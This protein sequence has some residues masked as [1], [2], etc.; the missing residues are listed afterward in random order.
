MKYSIHFI[1]VMFF[2]CT[3]AVYAQFTG[4]TYTTAESAVARLDLRDGFGGRVVRGNMDLSMMEGAVSLDGTKLPASWNSMDS[5]DGWHEL[6]QNGQTSEICVLNREDVVLEEGRLKQDTTWTGS[7]IHLIRNNIYVPNGVTLTIT[8]GVVVKFTEDTRIIV[9]NGGKISVQGTEDSP[10]QFTLATDDTYGGDTDLR[11]GTMDVPSYSLID[12]YNTSNGWEDNGQFVVRQLMVNA[13]PTVSIH[14]SRVMEHEGVVMIP[15]TVSGTRKSA[16]YVDWIAL[17]GTAKLENDYTLSSG[18]LS[19]STTDDGTQYIQIPIVSDAIVEDLEDFTVTLT[20]SSGTNIDTADSTVSICESEFVVSVDATYSWASFETNEP[21]EVDER[22]EVFSRLARKTENLRYSTTWCVSNAAKRVR[23]TVLLDAENEGAHEIFTSADYAEGMVEWK[24]SDLEMGRYII[25]H[26]TLDEHGGLLERLETRFYINHDIIVH[27]GC[28]TDDETWDDSAIHVVRSKVIVPD[29]VMLTI[30][31][32]AIVKFQSGSGIEAKPGGLV[33]CNGATFTHIADDSVGGDTN[34]DGNATMPVHNAYTLTG[35][36]PGADCKMCYIMQTLTGGTINGTMTLMGNCV[37]QVTGDITIESG[38]KLIVQPG[39]VVKME[40]GKSITVNSGGTLEAIGN[41]AQPIVFTSI[42]DD[43]HGGDTNGDG[44]KTMPQSGDWGRIN[45]GGTVNMNYVTIAYLNNTGDKGAIQGTG[46]TVTFDNGVIEYSVYECVR[47]NSGSFMARNSVFR[48]ASMGFGYY[49]GSGT[50]CINCVITDVT[51]GCR[52]SNKYFTNCVFY[53]VNSITDQGGDNSSFK[54]CVFYNPSGYGVQSYKKSGTNGNI[55]A[56]PLFNDP[57]NGDFTLKEGSPCIDAGDGSVAPELDYF[58]QPRQD[59]RD[60]TDTGVVAENGAVP[61]IGI[62]EMLPRNAAATVDL[63]A[64]SLKSAASVRAGERLAVEWTIRNDGT[65]AAVGSWRDYVYLVDASGEET[66]LGSLATTGSIA[67]NGLRVN[68]ADFIVPDVNEGEYYLK[69]KCNMNRDIF[70][71]TLTVNNIVISE[72]TVAITYPKVAVKDG[73]SGSLAAG[74]SIVKLL[75]VEEGYSLAL[76]QA[77][78]GTKVYYSLGSIPTV[79]SHISS[80]TCL[81]GMTMLSLPEGEVYLLLVA[82]DG[83]TCDYQIDFTE[84][85]LMIQSVSQTRLPSTGKSFVRV[86]GS[87]FGSDSEVYLIKGA[88]R[89]GVPAYILGDN[90][91]WITIE[92][93]KLSSGYYDLQVVSAL[94]SAIKEN[95]FVATNEEGSMNLSYQVIQPDSARVG[96]VF[97]ATLEYENTGNVAMPAPV[98][99][100]TATNRNF[101]I[102]GT[103]YQNKVMLYGLGTVYPYSYLQPGVHQKLTFQMQLLSGAGPMKIKAF[104]AGT[105]ASAQPIGLVDIFSQEYAE[106]LADND[107]EQFEA[108]QN[109]LG[110]TWND[111]YIGLADFLC[112]KNAGNNDGLVSYDLLKCGYL[113]YVERQSTATQRI[114][115]YGSE[116]N[117]QGV[118]SFTQSSMRGRGRC[119]LPIETQ[120]D[121]TPLWYNSSMDIIKPDFFPEVKDSQE[122]VKSKYSAVPIKYLESQKYPG[123]FAGDKSYPGQIWWFHTSCGWWHRLGNHDELFDK[124][125]EQITAKNNADNWYLICHGNKNSIYDKWILDAA[126]EI[127]NKYPNS[128]V[129]AVDWGDIARRNF[130]GMGPEDAAPFVPVVATEA[131]RQLAIICNDCGL[132]TNTLTVIG[133][134]HGAHL[135]GEIAKELLKKKLGKV[136]RFVGLDASPMWTHSK[137]GNYYYPDAWNSSIAEQVEFYKTSWRFSMGEDDDNEV[138]GMPSFY[139]I[140]S[141]DDFQRDLYDELFKEHKKPFKWYHGAGDSLTRHSF[142]H[143]WFIDTIKTI[144]TN[145]H[146]KIGFEWDGNMTSWQNMAFLDKAVAMPSKK[147]AGVI[148]GKQLELGNACVWSANFDMDGKKWKKIET[149]DW[150]YDSVVVNGVGDSALKRLW[151]ASCLAIEYHAKDIKI[152]N[153]NLIRAGESVKVEEVISKV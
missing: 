143:D 23:L 148:H 74:E 38:G 101:I 14:N 48:E 62:H 126:K 145:D 63:V 6:S 54:N 87:C 7:A 114:V 129:F 21:V 130:E 47:M 92:N 97:S 122:F 26:E 85:R 102:D 106:S 153:D 8:E 43:A 22:T 81:D 93:E 90:D 134:S 12:C 123:D 133:H 4:L 118:A 89:I 15:V 104:Y 77:P 128:N 137:K 111:F 35:F 52:A 146:N 61:D 83:E 113:R 100:I 76:I 32:G 82:P 29:G 152:N 40:S 30:S 70:E 13:L 41:R 58:G 2:F 31:H 80:V 147:F 151:Y 25:A 119:A 42:K 27:E 16:F 107:A 5:E 109:A 120:L 28:L 124:V 20:A 73:I 135:G 24:T 117:L 67:P 99:V 95:A 19:W 131:S 75:D 9:E 57:D 36:T 55:W 88:E 94:G 59:I 37:Y 18:R 33:E 98:F 3:V 45:A 60:V 78:K 53:R 10:V 136:K 1:F 108:L 150:K 39:T 132:N 127:S 49:G 68:K 51:V 144:S 149:R 72:E 91:I 112:G 50:Q 141:K 105:P 86:H 110:P 44:N 17:D 138:F 11:D 121:D 84:D 46:G 56:N 71:G 142:S 116:S 96:R 66:L 139:V 64:V 65:D 125:R 34:M 140:D 69:L 79:E 103:I 115:S